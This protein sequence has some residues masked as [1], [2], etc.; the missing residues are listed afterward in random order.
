MDLCAEISIQAFNTKLQILVQGRR[1]TSDWILG[2]KKRRIFRKTDTLWINAQFLMVA[3]LL[4]TA[5]MFSCN[6]FL[7]KLMELDFQVQQQLC[8]F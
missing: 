1:L 4:I 8:S 7:S 5:L 2:E 3:S 6:E